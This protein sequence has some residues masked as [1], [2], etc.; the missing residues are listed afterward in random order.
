[1][2]SSTGERSACLWLAGLL[3][4]SPSHLPPPGAIGKGGSHVGLFTRS[5]VGYWGVAGF[6][7]H[8]ERDEEVCFFSFIYFFIRLYGLSRSFPAARD[9]VRAQL[10]G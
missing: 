6:P 10:K 5:G 2:A 3:A 1:M 8:G 9:A 7:P 4:R